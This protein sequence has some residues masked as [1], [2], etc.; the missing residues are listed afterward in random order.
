MFACLPNKFLPMS[1]L[2]F[3]HSV[4]RKMLMVG[5]IQ[6]CIAGVTRSSKN[7]F[8]DGKNLGVLGRVLRSKKCFSPD[9]EVSKIQTILQFLF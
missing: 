1:T 8:L 2:F 6:L 4:T 5:T 9:S 7:A 3:P